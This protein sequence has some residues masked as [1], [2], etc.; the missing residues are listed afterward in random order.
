VA[1]PVP[2][3]DESVDTTTTAEESAETVA[4]VEPEPQYDPATGLEID[5]ATGLLIDP[6]T[7]YLLDLVNDRVI[8]PGTGYLVHPMTGLLIDPATGAQLDPVTLAI[9]IPAGFGSESPAYDPGSDAMRGT[10]ETVVD[11]TY[12]N[13]TYKVIPGTDG[14]VQPVG[15]IEVPTESGDAIEMS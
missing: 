10:I 8:H 11:E 2:T 4:A 14:P 13:A 7:G 15:E 12:D 9:V 3:T 5:P 1:E 6:A